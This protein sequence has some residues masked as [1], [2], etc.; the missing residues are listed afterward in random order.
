MIFNL[1]NVRHH[2]CDITKVSK[3][4][5]TDKCGEYFTYALKGYNLEWDS[6]PLEKGEK[7]NPK[8]EAWIL[9]KI[10]K[11]CDDKDASPECTFTR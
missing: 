11:W 6:I 10:R 4:S 8:D 7:Y 3:E 1:Q 5:K 9:D 2:I